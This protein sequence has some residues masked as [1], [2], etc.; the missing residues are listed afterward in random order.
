M[1]ISLNKLNKILFMNFNRIYAFFIHFILFINDKKK[2]QLSYSFTLFILNNFMCKTCVRF[3]P[4]DGVHCTGYNDVNNQVIRR[5]KRE[6]LSHDWVKHLTWKDIKW[7]NR[8]KHCTTHS[9]YK[10]I[11]WSKSKRKKNYTLPQWIHSKKGKRLWT[12]T[13]FCEFSFICKQTNKKT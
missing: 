3:F 5:S 1:I 7:K 13:I 4:I 6:Y 8:H 12:Q 11:L 9:Q 10:W 2:N